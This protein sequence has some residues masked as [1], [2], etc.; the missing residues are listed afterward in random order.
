MKPQLAVVGVGLMGGSLAAALRAAGFVGRITGIDTDP[1]ALALACAAGL[2]DGAGDLAAVGDT[3]I[4]VLATPVASL[5]Q[6]LADI[7]P[8]LSSKAVVTDMGS[9]KAP[10]AR[11]AAALRMPGFIPSHPIAGAEHSGPGAADATLFQDRVVIVTPTAGHDPRAL[12]LVEAMWTAVGA[13]V[14]RSE[15]TRHDHGVA[16]TSHLP[17]LLAFATAELL[18]RHDGGDALLPF[19]GTGLKD[20]LRIARS[21]PVMWRDICATNSNALGT[22]L[23]AYSALLAEYARSMAAGDGDDLRQHF[24]CARDYARRLGA[25]PHDG[26]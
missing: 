14:V 19:I 18:A 26:G 5:P 22:A 25:G 13:R 1:A 21:D 16:Y 20:F 15:P 12:D 6:L 7:K 9:V 2:I 8:L 4:V 23:S 3:D 10:V 24:A 11:A 17:H